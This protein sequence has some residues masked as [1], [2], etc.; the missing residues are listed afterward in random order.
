M[1]RFIATALGGATVAAP[2]SFND[3]VP[4]VSAVARVVLAICLFSL[5]ALAALT[6]L[7][8]RRWTVQ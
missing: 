8:S 4:L 1:T 2:L 5:V 7:W 6:A 3:A